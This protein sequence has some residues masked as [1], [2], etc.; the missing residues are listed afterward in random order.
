MNSLYARLALA[1]L[2]IIAVIGTGFFLIEQWS[3][4]QYHEELTQRLNASIA[5]Y[6]TEQ[7]PL[8]V[9]GEPN[10]EALAVLAARAMV[11]NPTAEVY[12][13]D[14]TGRVVAHGLPPEE[15]IQPQVDLA[16]VQ[17]L[18]AGSAEMPIH[19]TDPRNPAREKVFSASPVMDGDR[20]AGYLYVVLGGQAY[21]QLASSLRGSW[22]QTM[23]VGAIAAL[24]L[25]VFAAGLL[26]FAVLT[27]RLTRLTG[28]VQRFAAEALRPGHPPPAAHWHGDPEG[29]EIDRLGAAFASMAAKIHDQFERLDENDRLRREL[30]SNVSHDLRTPLASMQGYVDTL[31]MKNDRLDADERRHYLEITRKHTARLNTL[32]G[33]LFELSRLDAASDPLSPERF[34]LAELLHDV[35]QEF[36]L[37]AEK[38]GI[39]LNVDTAP[40]AA[41][42]EADIAL[43]Q[44]VLENLLRNALK[45][46]PDGGRVDLSL[47][48]L[49]D[50]V[51]VAV[52][53]TGCGI[54]E[55]RIGRI[56]DRF[57]HADD[58]ARPQDDSAGLGLAIVKR[59]LDLHGSRITV[60]SQPN[61]GTRF[62]FALPTAA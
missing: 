59:I 32:I 38:R 47:A 12:L 24:A 50:R 15:E 30:I 43:L 4:R 33:D 31:L 13:L 10:T 2:G 28:A 29:D 25:C 17:T 60:Q 20:V 1:L 9:D 36:E 52:A 14:E 26:L 27:R 18:M 35:A 46:T 51:S 58:E 6:V 8:Y 53:D 61:E 45:F 11:I 42:V 40:G 56:F 3:T 7:T 57:Y 21:D 49:G 44:R 5:M 48:P 55:E 62:E 23:S 37:D 22:V 54:P 41:V 16:P 34:S 19:G 39:T